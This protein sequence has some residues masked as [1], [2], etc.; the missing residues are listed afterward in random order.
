M[1]I[2]TNEESMFTEIFYN[3]SCLFLGFSLNGEVVPWSEGCHWNLI[4]THM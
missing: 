1:L 4:K 2:D 3:Y